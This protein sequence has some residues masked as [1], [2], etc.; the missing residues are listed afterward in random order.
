MYIEIRRGMYDLPQAGIL[1]NQLLTKQLEPKGYFQCHHISGLW[2]HRWR[3]VIFS[4]VVDD[5]GVKY[6]RKQHADHL[7]DS[8]R[9]H[10]SI[11]EDWAG[12][13]YC[14]ITLKWDYINRTV[15]LS[16]PGYVAA[17]L[18]KFQPPTPP[19]AQHA[20][21]K[22]REPIYG[23]TQQLTPPADTSAALPQEEIRI[24]QIT[25]T[26]LYYARTIDPTMQVAL[27]TIAS[28]QAKA[29]EETAAKIL[30]LLDYTPQPIQM[31]P[32]KTEPA[33]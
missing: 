17:A 5:F 23:A 12:E 15:D 16:M 28:Q 27:D 24:M 25:G 19:H 6:V 9:E 11:T 32:F 33:T 1:A 18:H 30:H 20:P 29:T 8:I 10:Y 7:C 2:R 4:L 26:L 21:H 3:P 22:W 13:L 31:Q 14:G